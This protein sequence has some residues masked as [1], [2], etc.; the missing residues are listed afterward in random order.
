L[1][2]ISTSGRDAAV[3]IIFSTDPFGDV[4]VR[5]AR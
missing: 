2:R 5:I 3:M 1:G 4:G